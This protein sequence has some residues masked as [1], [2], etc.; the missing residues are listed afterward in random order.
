MRWRL[1]KTITFT[2]NIISRFNNNKVKV[3]LLQPLVSQLAVGTLWAWR[4][5]ER[6][7][8][9]KKTKCCVWM[10]GSS[11][12]CDLQWVCSSQ[13]L[14]LVAKPGLFSEKLW[15]RTVLGLQTPHLPLAEQHALQLPSASVSSWATA[16]WNLELTL[17]ED[18]AQ[19]CGAVQGAV[20]VADECSWPRDLSLRNACS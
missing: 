6:K 18:R 2:L 3:V 17:P 16:L 13:A 5:W 10:H 4:H 11:R 7:T 1:P 8:S 15:H 12:L 14:L 19:M 20:L 9:S